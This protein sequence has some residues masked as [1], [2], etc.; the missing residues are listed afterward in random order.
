MGEG[1]TNG[2]N[3]NILKIIALISM[4]IDHIGTMFF[5]SLVIFKI[6]GRI[7]F[8]IFAYMIAEGWTYTSDRKR[9]FLVI[10]S[11]AFLYQLFYYLFY[12]SLSQGVF[13]TYSL[14][15]IF[16]FSIEKAIDKKGIYFAF[17]FIILLFL[18]AV[19]VYVP[20]KFIYSGFF[21]DYGFAGVLL[22][23]VVYFS[24]GKVFKLI[25][26]TID[27][28]VLGL[29]S[30]GIQLICLFSIPLLALYNGKRGNK[31]LKLFFYIYYPAHLVFIYLLSLVIL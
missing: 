3:G 25:A 30:G 8:P 31:N 28:M 23:V 11:M 1:R 18:V 15:L 6:I 5:P 19:T 27:L 13:V 16:I 4:T 21:I 20:N 12:S 10:L 29:V 7:S 9:Y 17:L 2:I 14:S 22:P 26:V 24:R